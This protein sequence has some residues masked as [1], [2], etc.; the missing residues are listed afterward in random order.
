LHSAG[1]RIRPTARAR[2]QGALPCGPA[3]AQHGRLRGPPCTPTR[4]RR[5][6]VIADGDGAVARAAT[7]RWQLTCYGVAGEGMT[8]VREVCRARKSA[9]GLTQSVAHHEGAGRWHRRSGGGQRRGRNGLVSGGRWMGGRG[10]HVGRCVGAG[11]GKWH[12]GEKSC[13]RAAESVFKGGAAGRVPRRDDAAWTSTARAR[14]LRALW[15]TA[16]SH[17]SRVCGALCEQ[18]RRWDAVDAG[19]AADKRGWVKTGP[20]RSG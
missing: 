10:G 5:I 18:G 3:A 6:A 11:E 17:A 12:G 8:A 9:V 4:E 15:T 13:Q 7:A 20:G 14:W 2:W 16:A 1:L 19:A